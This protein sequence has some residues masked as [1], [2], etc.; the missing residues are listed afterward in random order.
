MIKRAIYSI[1]AAL[2]GVAGVA[3]A[4]STAVDKGLDQAGATV[5]IQMS[6]TEMAG[7]VAG[8]ANRSNTVELVEP[9]TQDAGNVLSARPLSSKGGGKSAYFGDVK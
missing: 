8:S 6:E 5:A 3:Q 1:P 7:I 4:D 2:M 9:R